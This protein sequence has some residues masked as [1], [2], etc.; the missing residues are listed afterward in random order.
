[1]PGGAA[2]VGSLGYQMLVAAGTP[3]GR[4]VTGLTAATLL[5]T[6]TLVVLPVFSLPA[7]FAGAPVGRS[8][9]RA[10]EIGVA[11]AVLIVA[12]GAVVLFTDRLLL[13]LGRRRAPRPRPPE[14]GRRTA[15][16][17]A[18]ASRRGTR[19]HQALPR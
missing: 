2:S 4:A 15:R 14:A 6:A 1:M 7:I 17:A 19:P 13:W 8:L 18:G 3:K 9:V 10:L 11:A 16:R 12:G 5:S